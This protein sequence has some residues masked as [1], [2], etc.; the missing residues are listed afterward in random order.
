MLEYE[1]H[2]KGIT[3]AIIPN[4]STIRH[5]SKV[6][7]RKWL[8]RIYITYIQLVIQYWVLNYETTS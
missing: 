2:L 8:I 1:A 3:K 6:Y 5:F 4:V 7:D